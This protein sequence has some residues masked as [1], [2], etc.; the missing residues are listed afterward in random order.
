MKRIFD[1]ITSL[2]GLIIFTPL[3]F[4]ISIAILV[5]DGFPILFV[6]ARLGK[7][8]EEFNIIKFRTM[9]VG[10]SISSANDEMRQTLLGKFLRKSSLDE[11]PVLINVLKGEMSLVGPRPL[12]IK[13]SKRFNS[14]QNRRHEVLPGITG[15]AQ[16]KG[17]NQ[18]SWEEKFIYDVQYI[19]EH[20]FLLDIKILFKTM[21]L[22]LFFKGT[23]PKGQDIMSEFMGSKENENN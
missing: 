5:F 3:L 14:F 22:V 2:I 23:S 15:L 19:D 4:L 8:K 10:A 18:I 12:L 16:I 17:R 13:Y 21:N 1:I 6:Q 20:N 9:K 11:L 7:D